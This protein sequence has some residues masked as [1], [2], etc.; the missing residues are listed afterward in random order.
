MSY[1]DFSTIPKIHEKISEEEIKK[2]NEIFQSPGIVKKLSN[3]EKNRIIRK[4]VYFFVT[5]IFGVVFFSI[6]IYNLNS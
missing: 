2:L 1:I 5:I 3:I 4:F 6:S